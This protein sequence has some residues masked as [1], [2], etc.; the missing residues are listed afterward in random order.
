MILIEYLLKV[1][2]TTDDIFSS[3]L[4]GI[5]SFGEGIQ[6]IV[7]GGIQLTVNMM[8]YFTNSSVVGTA[9]AYL[10]IVVVMGFGYVLIRIIIHL[11]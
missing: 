2:T 10:P 7:T 9:F 6:A 3:L 8:A 11:L 1:L 4:T 5:S